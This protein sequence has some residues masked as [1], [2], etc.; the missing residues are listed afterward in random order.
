[1]LFRS[2]DVVWMVLTD[3][4]KFGLPPQYIILWDLGD[5]F[6][7]AIDTSQVNSKG[8]CP[9]KGSYAFHSQEAEVED[10]F[11]DFGDFLLDRIQKEVKYQ[12]EED[13]LEEQQ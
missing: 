7:C 2:P 8:E 3:R 13:W 4:K 11:E 1:M 12:E 6:Q 9:I 5:G 10:C